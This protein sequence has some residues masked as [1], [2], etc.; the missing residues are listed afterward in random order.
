MVMFTFS[1]FNWKY[2]FWENLARKI[3]EKS[4]FLKIASQ[5]FQTGD[6]LNIFI[7]F[8]GFWGSL[9]IKIF[10]IKK[11]FFKKIKNEK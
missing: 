1:V 11:N 2:T 3:K 5:A 7:R 6:F 4:A 8:W 9:F 10:L